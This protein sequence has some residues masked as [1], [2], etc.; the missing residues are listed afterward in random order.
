MMAL[1]IF[2]T[3]GVLITLH[4]VE[5]DQRTTVHSQAVIEAITNFVRNRVLEAAA[6]DMSISPLE[7]LLP[8]Y[9]TYPVA[10]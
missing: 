10:F 7:S 6:P 9:H 8:Q 1:P 5:C 4:S 2:Y 3:L